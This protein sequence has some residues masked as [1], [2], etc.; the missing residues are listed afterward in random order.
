VTAL[1]RV[2]VISDVH[3]NAPALEAVLAEIAALDVDLIVS[4]G[5]LLAGPLPVETAALLEPLGD[6]V[7]HVRGN[8]DREVMAVYD[9]G[10]SPFDGPSHA[11]KVIGERERALLAT[12]APTVLV[13]VEGLGDV[14]CCHGTPSSDETIVTFLTSDERLARELADAPAPTVVGGHTHMQVDRTVGD[15]RYVNAGS[16]G[17]PYEGMPGAYWAL[18][19]PDVEHRRT[20]YEVDV[21][22]AAVL[23]SGMQGADEFAAILTTPPG[24][25]ETARTFEARAGS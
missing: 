19:G 14:C 24:R 12:F 22:A 3:G 2:A 6:R 18:L 7:R 23:G 8:A 20:P 13:T 15:R 4:C 1:H 17:M 5:D 10:S 9:G 25:E 16:V 11:G 21:A